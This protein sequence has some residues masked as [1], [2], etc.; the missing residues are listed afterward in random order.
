MK[1]NELITNDTLNGIHID[2][3]QRLLKIKERLDSSVREKINLE[4]LSLEFGISKSKL[5][6]DFKTVFNNSVY[7]YFM[8]SKMNKAHKMLQSKQKNISQ[9]AY[10][11]GYDY[12]STFSQM[13]KKIK[14][15]SPSEVTTI[16]K[17]P[18]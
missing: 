4:N 8:I 16:I 13:F 17:T 6:R 5:K 11:L 15:F 1:V 10:E 12:P 14:G 7:Q 3:Y 2:D 18:K 9:I